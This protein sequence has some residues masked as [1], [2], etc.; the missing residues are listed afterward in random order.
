MRDV[1]EQR[2]LSVTERVREMLPELPAAQRTVA[3]LI[4]ADPGRVAQLNVLDLAEVCGVSTGSIARL[5]RALGLDGYASLRISLAAD[6]GRSEREAWD[7]DIGPDIAAE[8]DLQ[9]VATVISTAITG[10][11]S[12]TL[13]QVDLPEVDRAADALVGAGR[14]HLVGFGGSGASATECMGRLHRVGI[15]TWAITDVH[16]AMSGM[17][18]LGAGDV[19]VAI[20]HSGRTREVLDLIA[21]AAARGAIVV[22]VT[23]DPSSPIARHADIVLR[24]S[25]GLDGFRS[26]GVL[27]RHAQLAVL[28]LLYV[29]VVQ[30]TS[31]QSAEALTATREAVRAYLGRESD[32]DDE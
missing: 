32:G 31:A 5:C 4:M 23:N 20:S 18:V 27:A 7:S 29:A 1:P 2:E 3:E 21:E 10:T 19:V 15:P 8:D 24:T 22:A 30:R 6:S 11:V 17:A 28:D 12:N 14:V 26:E 16:T 25:A 13:N 9:R